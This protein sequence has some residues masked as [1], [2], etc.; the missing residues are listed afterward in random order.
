M[1]YALAAASLMRARLTGWRMLTSS[2]GLRL[3]MRATT[4][5]CMLRSLGRA[6]RSLRSAPRSL[7]VTLARFKGPPA[8]FHSESWFWKACMFACLSIARM[9][10][11]LLSSCRRIRRSVL[12]VIPVW[13][14]TSIMS[15]LKKYMP[16]GTCG[17]VSFGF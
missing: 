8:C 17:V 4:G 13:R 16:H 2:L 15:L 14:A 12:F 1:V 5:L 7:C 11:L 3:L 9:V 6:V 10:R